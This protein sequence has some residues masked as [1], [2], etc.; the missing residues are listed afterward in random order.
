MISP[1]NA[2][3]TSVKLIGLLLSSNSLIRL[4]SKSTL[5]RMAGAKLKVARLENLHEE[6]PLAKLQD[7]I[8]GEDEKLTLG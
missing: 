7:T 1:V 2:G 8:I 4:Q 3:N 6:F 5:S